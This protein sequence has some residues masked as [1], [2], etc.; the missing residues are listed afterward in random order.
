[1]KNL[2]ASMLFFIGL[3]ANVVNAEEVS[4]PEFAAVFQLETSDGASVAGALTKFAQSDC[5][6]NMPTSIRIMAESFNGDL[7]I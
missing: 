6:K 1:M 5:R 7:D 3:I 2:V 4:I